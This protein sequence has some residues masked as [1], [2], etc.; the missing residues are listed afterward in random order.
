MEN[1]LVNFRPFKGRAVKEGQKVRVYK[2]LTNGL[3]SIKDLANGY[4][5]GH[6]EHVVL[7]NCNFVVSEKGKERVVRERKKYV[8]AFV[9]GEFESTSM[10]AINLK[11]I[12]YHDVTYNPFKEGY[13]T[14]KSDRTKKLESAYIVA[15]TSN[16]QVVSSR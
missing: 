11:E 9:E 4:V 6:A 3:W 13:F 7:V 10:S 2:N 5:L 15:L 14:L 8:H 1:I 16:D 12:D